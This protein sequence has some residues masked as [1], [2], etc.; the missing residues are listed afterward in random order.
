MGE[1]EGNRV[2]RLGEKVVAGTLSP[3]RY[4]DGEQPERLASSN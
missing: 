3:H 2:S 1:R 4:K